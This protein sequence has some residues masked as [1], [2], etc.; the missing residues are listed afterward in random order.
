[1]HT[2]QISVVMPKRAS[3]ADH[4]G[5]RTVRIRKVKGSNPSVSQKNRHAMRASVCQITPAFSKRKLGFWRI[6]AGKV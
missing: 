4:S 5:E 6:L 1:M 3:F 2:N